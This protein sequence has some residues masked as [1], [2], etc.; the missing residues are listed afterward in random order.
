MEVGLETMAKVR[1]LFRYAMVMRNGGEGRE[2]KS[3]RKTQGAPNLHTFW[4]EGKI[5]Y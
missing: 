2:R 3:A 4:K 1:W 5:T